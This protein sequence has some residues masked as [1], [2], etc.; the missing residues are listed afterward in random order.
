MSTETPHDADLRHRL[1]DLTR[2]TPAPILWLIGKTQSGKTSI[3]KFLT[4]AEE[5]EIG[6]GFAPCTRFS[7]EYAFPSKDIPLLKFL[8]T[9]GLE[10]PGY[11]A[12]EDMAAFNS[13]AHVIII[14]IRV[15]DHA[16]AGMIPHL[17]QIRRSQPGRPVILALTCLHEAYPQQQHPLPFPFDTSGL[18]ETS[19]VTS[20][21][22]RSIDRHRQEL[23]GLYDFVAPLDIT[24]AYEGFIEPNYGGQQFINTLVQA[25][26]SAYRQTLLMLEK[27]THSLQEHHAR[28]AL[29]YIMGYS[30]LA[31]TAGA[32]P[33]PWIDLFFLP[34]IQTQMIHRI[35]RLYG[36]PLNGKRFLELASTL[37][38]GI[39]VRQA[40]RE[41]AKFIPLFGSAL[42]AVLAGSS[43]F[44]LGKAFCYYY[45]AVHQGHVPQAS[46]LKRYYQD[47]LTQAEQFWKKR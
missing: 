37:G 42:G 34:A 40:I 5:A 24:P 41:L 16:L 14:T 39:F 36:Q 23:A 6:L 12:G 45:S 27:M 38:L 32:F 29:P 46:D 2:K 35:A 13:Q 33:I 21:L 11:D 18:I 10:E 31:A 8:D 47:Q 19:S 15:L 25:L 1:D 26:P 20:E 4:G 7:R 17:R 43:T 22:Q 28:K 30:T 3:I 44:A 9:R